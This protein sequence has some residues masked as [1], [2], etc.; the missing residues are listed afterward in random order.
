[1]KFI[2]GLGVILYWTGSVRGNITICKQKTAEFPLTYSDIQNA[3]KELGLSG[4]DIHIDHLPFNFSHP[5]IRIAGVFDDVTVSN[6]FDYTLEKLEFID[7]KNFL[8]FNITFHNISVNGLYDM[9]GNIG[10]LF[11]IFGKG[12]YW[13][14]MINFNIIATMEWPLFD[15]GTAIC[16][17]SN[18]DVSLQQAKSHFYNLMEDPELEE[19]MNDAMENMAPEIVQILW[20]EAKENY[21]DIIKKI[22]EHL[23]NGNIFMGVASHILQTAV[24]STK[25]FDILNGIHDFSAHY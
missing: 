9:K 12:K 16:A 11:N 1:M 15:N 4:K 23:I 10:E 7:K 20:E 3:V 6:M 19:L 2:L 18:V 21:D 13:F 24:R 25:E 22:I 17:T 5:A 14:Q 8:I